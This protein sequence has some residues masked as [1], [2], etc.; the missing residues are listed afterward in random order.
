MSNIKVGT[1][2]KLTFITNLNVRE[3]HVFYKDLVYK[4]VN[5]QIGQYLKKILRIY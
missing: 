5:G 4:N 3:L 2:L 1:F